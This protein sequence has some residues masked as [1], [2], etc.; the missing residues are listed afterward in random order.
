[1]ERSSDPNFQQSVESRITFRKAVS[2]GSDLAA[3]AG[4]MAI[5]FSLISSIELRRVMIG[6]FVQYNSLGF[7]ERQQPF[8]STFSSDA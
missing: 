6:C 3:S 4:H 2:F 7:Q 5:I 1:M 8:G